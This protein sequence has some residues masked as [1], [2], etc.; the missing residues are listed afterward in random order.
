MVL[1]IWDYELLVL[2]ETGHCSLLFCRHTS[3]MLKPCLRYPKFVRCAYYGVW[4]RVYTFKRLAAVPSS[5]S[6]LS[7]QNTHHIRNMLSSNKGKSSFHAHSTTSSKQMLTNQKR[8]CWARHLCLSPESHGDA[9]FPTCVKV[10]TGSYHL[11]VHE[12]KETQMPCKVYG[13][14]PNHSEQNKG[15]SEVHIKGRKYMHDG[16]LDDLKNCNN[17]SKYGANVL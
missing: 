6:T 15:K 12:A 10:I 5:L 3:Q 14:L 11:A 9:S 13:Q 16:E 7:K 2:T 1:L 8:F 17:I 4:R